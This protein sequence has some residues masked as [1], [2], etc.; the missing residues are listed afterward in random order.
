MSF[1]LP[2]FTQ[3]GIFQFRFPGSSFDVYFFINFDPFLMFEVIMYFFITCFRVAVFPRFLHLNTKDFFCFAFMGVWSSFANP[4]CFISFPFICTIFF[5]F[6]FRGMLSSFCLPRFFHLY[7]K[8]FSSLCFH[9]CGKYS[10]FASSCFLFSS[11]VFEVIRI[12]FF[13][14]VLWCFWV[15]VFI[16]SSVYTQRFFTF[17]FTC[18]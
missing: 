3:E 11:L 5:F 15:A 12:C 10:S 2:P 7:T 9:V 13:V 16:S 14:V 18:M 4:F 17:P 1:S 8:G 6:W